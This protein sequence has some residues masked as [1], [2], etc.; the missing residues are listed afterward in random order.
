MKKKTNGF[1]EH[2][3]LHNLAHYLPAQSPLKD[4]VHHN[5]L[6]SFQDKK[7]LDALQDASAI[8]GYKTYLPL[9]DFRSRYHKGQINSAILK[10]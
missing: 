9:A 2:E 10:K 4:F 1:D 5:T 8:F 7:F 3:V 6:H